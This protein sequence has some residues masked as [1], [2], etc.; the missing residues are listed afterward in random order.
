MVDEQGPRSIF[1]DALNPAL[2]INV[3][4]GPPK[5]ETGRPENVYSL[6]TPGLTQLKD[7][8][9]EPVRLQ[10]QVGRRRH[11][12]GRQGLDPAGRLGRAG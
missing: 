8:N 11:A 3:W 6:D 9:G 10:L 12:A 5:T 4:Y 1:P 7:A 2:F